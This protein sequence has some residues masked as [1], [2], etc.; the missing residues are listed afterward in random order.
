[1]RKTTNVMILI[2]FATLILMMPN[3]AR[4]ADSTIKPINPGPTSKPTKWTAETPQPADIGTSNFRFT[5]ATTQNQTFF[6]NITI[7]NVTNLKTWGVGLIFDNSTL[8]YVSAWRPTDH[9]FSPLEPDTS[10]V[11]PSVIIADYNETHQEV[12]WGC[13]YIMP[14]PTWV[15]NGTG[16]LCQIQF[17][18]IKTTGTVENPLVAVFGFDP[19]WTGVYFYPSGNEVPNFQE[20]FFYYIPEFTPIIL[21]S[22]LVIASIVI[23]FAR[24][25]NKKELST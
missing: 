8:A 5:T 20:G 4:A 16:V 21:L 22:A 19:S 13:G 14:D 12:Q 23:A 11:A 9:V 18:I 25:R 24:N 2:A 15:F 1:M 6:I 17:K 10:M 3:L 7:S